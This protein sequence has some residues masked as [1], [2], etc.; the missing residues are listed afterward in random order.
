[1]KIAGI[2]VANGIKDISGATILISDS[3]NPIVNNIVEPAK[4]IEF[5]TKEIQ[6]TYSVGII[7]LFDNINNINP[8]TNR[9]T[10]RVANDVIYESVSEVAIFVAKLFPDLKIIVEKDANKPKLI[11][12]NH[13]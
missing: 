7:I 5:K 12:Y 11:I 3:L 8:V 10:T 2:I 1:M 6:N 4:D 13:I 9:P